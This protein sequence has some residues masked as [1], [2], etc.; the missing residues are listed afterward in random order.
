MIV[1]LIKRVNTIGIKFTKGEFR[2]SHLEEIVE[3]ILEIPEDEVAGISEMGKFRFMI[4]VSTFERY[5]E[6]CENY[7]GQLI[8][9]DENIEIRIEDVSTYK[10]RVHMKFV[11]FEL[12]NNGL[13][14]LL[15]NFGK[16][17]NIVSCYRRQGKYKGVPT[18]EHITMKK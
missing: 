14:I 10:N 5:N 3:N 6:I 9:I 16:V 4:K 18:D 12:G 17:E 11:P 2:E 7:V 15:E 8:P 13:K 1:P